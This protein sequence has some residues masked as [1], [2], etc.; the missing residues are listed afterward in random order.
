MTYSVGKFYMLRLTFSVTA[1]MCSLFIGLE[2]KTDIVRLE[3]GSIIHITRARN[4]SLARVLE[5]HSQNEAVV[6][7]LTGEFEESVP[8]R[9]LNFRELGQIVP[10]LRG[11]HHGTL[12]EGAGIYAAL[13]GSVI[14]VFSDG[15]VEI[16]DHSRDANGYPAHGYYGVSPYPGYHPSHSRYSKAIVP[17]RSLRVLAPYN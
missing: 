14:R 13:S 3:I 4:H 7:I 5:V 10:E 6:Q 16:Y 9:T 8:N 12:I 1:L 2:A 11:I 15:F 17:M